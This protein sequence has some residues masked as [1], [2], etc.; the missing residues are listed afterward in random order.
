MIEK[1]FSIFVDK[2][3]IN[4]NNISFLDIKKVSFNLNGFWS[5]VH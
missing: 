5:K 4:I 1:S 3:T 2:P